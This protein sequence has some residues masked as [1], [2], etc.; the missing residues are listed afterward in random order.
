M[1]N[2]NDYNW[3]DDNVEGFEEEIKSIKAEYN[4]GYAAE[5]VEA[6]ELDW[7]G[8]AENA[9]ASCKGHKGATLQDWLDYFAASID[10][11]VYDK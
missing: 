11:I 4:K 2:F 6:T 3:N 8:A 10:G 1:T 7:V 5:G 9:E